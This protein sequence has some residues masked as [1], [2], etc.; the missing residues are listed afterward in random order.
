MTIATGIMA[1]IGGIGVIA[2]IVYLFGG[3]V[4]IDR[5]VER[6]KDDG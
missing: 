3:Q 5:E 4:L 2:I 1:W 6:E